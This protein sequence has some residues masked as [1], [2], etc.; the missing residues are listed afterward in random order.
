MTVIKGARVILRGNATSHP[1]LL[2]C[3]QL[4]LLKTKKSI[5]CSILDSP[6]NKIGGQKQH[7]RSSVNWKGKFIF[8]L[9]KNLSTFSSEHRL[10][11]CQD[12]WHLGTVPAVSLVEP[13]SIAYVEY[14]LLSLLY[15][16]TFCILL[17]LFY[18]L[19]K[20]LVC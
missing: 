3:K 16:S 5:F 14:S 10:L 12:L 7:S 8:F 1:D 18:L 6:T 2:E 9:I 13:I 17:K 15:T 4:P 19:E 20:P 11:V